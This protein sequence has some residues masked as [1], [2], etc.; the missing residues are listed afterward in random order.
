MSLY[1]GIL[2]RMGVLRTW[3]VKGYGVVAV[4]FPDHRIEHYFLHCSR[5]VFC[6]PEEPRIGCSVKFEVSPSRLPDRYPNCINAYVYEPL[7]PA[8]TAS[9]V[10]T[11]ALSGAPETTQTGA[12]R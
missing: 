3:G 5:I 10:V 9:T 11:A 12:A 2:S 8:A 6:E 7:A 4:K 1:Y